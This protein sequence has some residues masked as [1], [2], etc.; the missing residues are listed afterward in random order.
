MRLSERWGRAAALAVSGALAAALGGCGV[1]SLT[2]D[3]GTGAA[4]RGECPV[5]TQSGGVIECPSP[6]LSDF[7]DLA[8][9]T[10]T[11]DGSPPRNGSW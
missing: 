8:L 4:G 2:P 11:R 9:A 5:V 1:R 6:R 10:I 3:G 7:E